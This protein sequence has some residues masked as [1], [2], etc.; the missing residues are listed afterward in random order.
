[1]TNENKIYYG[2]HLY[3]A[4]RDCFME[5]A[6]KN[7]TDSITLEFLNKI[8]N[9]LNRFTN[10]TPEHIKHYK[11]ALTPAKLEIKTIQNGNFAGKEYYNISGE[12]FGYTGFNEDVYIFLN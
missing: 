7:R 3:I 8:Q 5:S 4:G 9:K 1:M 6:A 2:F 10:I 12:N 11:N